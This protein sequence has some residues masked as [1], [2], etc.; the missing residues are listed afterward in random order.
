MTPRRGSLVL[1]LPPATM[2]AGARATDR[3]VGFDD[4]KRRLIKLDFKCK[5]GVVD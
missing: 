2:H 4:P 5:L 3:Y 1:V